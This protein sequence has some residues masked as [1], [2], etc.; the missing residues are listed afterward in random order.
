MKK[1]I[2]FIHGGY[3]FGSKKDYLDFLKNYELD[4]YRKKAYWINWIA[5]KLKREYEVLVPDMPCEKNAHYEEWKIWFEKYFKFIKDKN[6]ILI[7]HSLGAIFLLKYMSENNFPKKIY[8]LHLSAPAVFDDGL[9][10]E[11]LSTFKADIKKINKIE[12]K[13]KELHLWHS[14]DDNICLFKNSEIIKKI[15]PSANFHI[16]KNKGHFKQPAFPGLLKV[17]KEAR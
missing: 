10:L 16:F 1:Q 8:Q 5:L 15:I 12:K 3:T 2:L 13:C 14:M 11:K 9:G 6:P 7:G 17:I 4:P